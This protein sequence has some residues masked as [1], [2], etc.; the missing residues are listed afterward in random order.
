M[1]L[2]L[3]R[4]KLNHVST[5]EKVKWMLIMPSEDKMKYNNEHFEN[6]PYCDEKIKKIVVGYFLML[7]FWELYDKVTFRYLL[8]FN[9]SIICVRGIRGEGLSK[10]GETRV[11]IDALIKAKEKAVKQVQVLSDAKEKGCETSL[12]S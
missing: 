10:E 5:L 11:I 1:N 4:S 3:K 9:G 12:K 8:L 7:C 6:D 2:L